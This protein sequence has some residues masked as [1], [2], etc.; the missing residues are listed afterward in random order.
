MTDS[1]EIPISTNSKIMDR[2]IPCMLILFNLSVKIIKSTKIKFFNSLFTN[3]QEYVLFMTFSNNFY[4]IGVLVSLYFFY[5]IVKTD[6]RVIILSVM[7]YRLFFGLYLIVILKNNYYFSDSLY[8]IISFG[9]GFLGDNICYVSLQYIFLKSFYLKCKTKT[10]LRFNIYLS[11]GCIIGELLAL[12]YN[13]FFQIQEFFITFVFYIIASIFIMIFVLL[14]ES[15]PFEDN[16]NEENIDFISIITFRNII[17]IKNKDIICLILLVLVLFF[18]I[19]HVEEEHYIYLNDKDSHTDFNISLFVLVRSI[20]S[21]LIYLLLLKY[22]NKSN[23]NFIFI[24]IIILALVARTLFFLKHFYVGILF[25][26]PFYN[27]HSFI[28]SKIITLFR[29]TTDAIFILSI[30]Y[31]IS[32]ILI[33][34][35]YSF[36]YNS[37]QEYVL[38]LPLIITVFLLILFLLYILIDEYS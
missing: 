34:W 20:L 4:Y 27:I 9:N 14:L 8:F 7:I 31:N 16:T 15:I 1:N 23:T 36:V 25:L 2:I 11:I 38:L 29:N 13:I 26:I 10:I 17:K 5:K 22:A 12:I 35:C 19:F 18:F 3:N 21:L 24:I 6:K 30:I 33:N 32:L 28:Y 37:F